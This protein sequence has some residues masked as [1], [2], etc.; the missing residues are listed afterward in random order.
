MSVEEAE[1]AP[2]TFWQEVIDSKTNHPYYWNPL[3]NEVV[4]S[5]P[6]GGVIYSGEE[7]TDESMEDS[8]ASV[9]KREEGRGRGKEGKE[10]EKE[11]KGERGRGRGEEVRGKKKGNGGGGSEGERREGTG[12]VRK[13][14]SATTVA[15]G[16]ETADRDLGTGR[17][18]GRGV[19]KEE[20][21]GERAGGGGGRREVEEESEIG[22]PLP[23]GE[24]HVHV[25]ISYCIIYIYYIVLIF[26]SSSNTKQL[27]HM[28]ESIAQ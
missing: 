10:E 8:D 24:S 17:D 7:K 1:P 12:V 21:V 20:A 22:P 14:D 25:Y 3:T 19:L 6:P 15:S 9:V 23:P 11:G 2:P 5:L 4:W 18:E 13:R 28:N 26:H 27:L 16:K